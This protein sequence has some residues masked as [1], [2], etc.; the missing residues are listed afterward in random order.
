MKPGITNQGHGL[1]QGAVPQPRFRWDEDEMEISGLEMGFLISYCTFR[2]HTRAAVWEETPRCWGGMTMWM[3][4]PPPKRQDWS[5]EAWKGF[6]GSH[7]KQGIT[8]WSQHRSG[9]GHG[10]VPSV[11]FIDGFCTESSPAK[12]IESLEQKLHS[13]SGFIISAWFLFLILASLTQ[14]LISSA[15]KF[16]PSFFTS[17]LSTNFLS[18]LSSS[19][20]TQ[21]FFTPFTPQPGHLIY[22]WKVP[23]NISLLLGL[24]PESWISWK[25]PPKLPRPRLEHTQPKPVSPGKSAVKS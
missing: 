13:N 4:G 7:S 22:H 16:K 2:N 12:H 1:G 15:V 11:G 24:M 21:V 18:P 25:I 23:R 8:W 10:S 17:F 14:Y 6:H 20:A 19:I 3:A 5:A 9:K